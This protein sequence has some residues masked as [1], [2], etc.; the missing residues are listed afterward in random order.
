[1][2][3][4]IDRLVNGHCEPGFG[5]VADVLSEHL[6]SGRDVGASVGVYLDGRPVVDIWGG[7]ADQERRIRWAKDT[8]TPIGSIPRPLPRPRC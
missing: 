7:F 1:M 2:P 4:T 8:V 5:P 3:A 6:H